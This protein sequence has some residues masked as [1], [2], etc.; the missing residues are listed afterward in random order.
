MK[1][2]VI[3]AMERW[4]LPTEH[5]RNIYTLKYEDLIKDKKETLIRL[6]PIFKVLFDSANII[7]PKKVLNSVKFTDE[8]KEYYLKS[9]K[10]SILTEEQ[11]NEVNEIFDIDF[12]ESIGYTRL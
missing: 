5:G 1:F 6:S 9:K 8:K 2:L 10:I 7:E 12:M 3:V 11:I 4:V